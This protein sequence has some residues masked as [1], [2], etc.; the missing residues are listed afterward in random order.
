[1]ITKHHCEVVLEGYLN[2][3]VDSWHFY[4]L[5]LLAILDEVLSRFLQVA[6]FLRT[7]AIAWISYGNSVHLFV[8]HNPVSIRAQMR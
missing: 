2:K 6:L 8:H 4:R 1:M 3:T 5:M 7:R